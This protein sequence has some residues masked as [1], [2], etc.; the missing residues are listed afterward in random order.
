MINGVRAIMKLSDCPCKSHIAGLIRGADVSE[1]Q[2]HESCRHAV[3][4]DV[5]LRV[6]RRR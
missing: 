2:P 5:I 1:L 3:T 6:R 4:K